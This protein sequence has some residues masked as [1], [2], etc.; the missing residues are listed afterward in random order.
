MNQTSSVHGGGQNGLAGSRSRPAHALLASF[1]VAGRAPVSAGAVATP[2][3][4]EAFR[5]WLDELPPEDYEA[6]LQVRRHGFT[7]DVA[8]LHAQL[9][10]ALAAVPPGPEGDAAG[11]RLLGLLAQLAGATCFLLEEGLPQTPE[12]PGTTRIV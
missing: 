6:L 4:C 10:R 7:Y 8:A 12:P 3:E 11:R 1:C 5:H 2:T 9:S